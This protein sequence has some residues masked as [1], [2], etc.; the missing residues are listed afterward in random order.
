MPTP[1]PPTFYL[2][3]FFLFFSLFGVFM[4]Y[5]FLCTR[6]ILANDF[7]SSQHSFGSS[8]LGELENRVGLRIEG[9]KEEKNKKLGIRVSIETHN[10]ASLLF[11]IF[12]GLAT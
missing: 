2:F 10:P 6:K 7:G 11:V 5:H 1:P 8:N 3:Y 12:G 4:S 9:E